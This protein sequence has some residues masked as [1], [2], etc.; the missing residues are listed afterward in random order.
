LGARTAVIVFDLDDAKR[1]EVTVLPG[2]DDA[3]RLAEDLIEAGVEVG[4]I[5]VLAG[6]ELSVNIAHKVVVKLGGE[7]A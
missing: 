3:A 6:T 2:V 4:R 5:R 7:Q 1:G